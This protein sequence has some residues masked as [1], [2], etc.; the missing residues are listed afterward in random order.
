[1][2]GSALDLKQLQWKQSAVLCRIYYLS[3]EFYMGR[4]LQN[5]MV[6]L[7]LQNACDEAIYQAPLQQHS[8]LF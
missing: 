2:L 8:D 4:T 3:L 6:N 1:M 7:G 5:T